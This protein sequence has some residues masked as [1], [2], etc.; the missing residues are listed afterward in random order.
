[1]PDG[2]LLAV[3]LGTSGCK[4][5]LFTPGLR[6]VAS[7]TASYETAYPAPDEAEQDPAEWWAAFVAGTRG[8]LGKARVAPEEVL[9]VS[10]SGQMMGCLPVDAAGE[11]LSPALIWA[12]QRSR[13]AAAFLEERV[14]TG[15][16]YRI[17]G[18]R[19]HPTYPLCKFRWL[20]THRPEVY[21]GCHKFL[22]AKDYLVLRLTGEWATDY[23]D[24]SGTA[25]LDIA[26]LAWS[27]ELLSAAEVDVAKLPKLRPAAT[28][29]GGLR[30]EAAAACGLKEGMPVVLGGG[31]GPCATAGTGVAA[32][33]QAY[34]YLGSSSWVSLVTRQPGF[35]PEQRT[36][37][38]C[39]LDPLI[40][41]QFG[42]MQCGGGAVRW[43][44]EAAGLAEEA[45]RR[46]DH[47]LLYDRLDEEAARAA[48]GAGGVL[49]L[50]YLM[51]ERSPYYN[52]DARG[53]FLGLT[54]RTGRLELARAVLEGVAL[55]LRIILEAFREQ[56]CR[57]AEV[58]AIGG[59]ASSPV[60]LGIIA[61]V[62][63]EAVETVEEPNEAT[64]RG[65]AMAGAVA[66]GLV[67]DYG[68][69]AT[70]VRKRGRY[71]PTRDNERRATYDRAYR[72]FRHAYQWLLPYYTAARQP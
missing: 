70:L 15:E 58:R 12:D 29:V 18:N 49:F 27:E 13:D 35:D 11:P 38:I 47:E 72:L 51:G 42:T 48:P 9:A 62:L 4:A 52:V 19:L 43:F 2:Y 33:G 60:W 67:P 28:V 64:S 21:A 59:G 44:G 56:G 40:A 61:D 36:F 68:A 6:L 30:A 46:G 8:V 57:V 41:N 23:S 3:D 63:G 10:F 26:R 31:D 39:H 54:L 37:N 34:L 45:R 32:E 65:A 55:N 16:F 50:P 17:A 5:A 7:H 24:A 20:K 1:M 69:A 25:A 66:L 22:Q 53:A 71:E 14:G